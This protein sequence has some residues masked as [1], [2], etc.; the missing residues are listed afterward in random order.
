MVINPYGK[1]MWI[2]SIRLTG[3]SSHATWITYKSLVSMWHYGLLD[4]CVPVTVPLSFPSGHFLVICWLK[5]AVLGFALLLQ[6]I[7]SSNSYTNNWRQTKPNASL[8]GTGIAIK[9]GHG[10]KWGWPFLNFPFLW[11]AQRLRISLKLDPQTLCWIWTWS[12]MQYSIICL[13]PLGQKEDLLAHPKLVCPWNSI[14][15]KV[16]ESVYSDCRFLHKEVGVVHIHN[17]AF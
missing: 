9:D 7:A 5:W 8:Q 6:H 16:R 11:D 12:F 1:G 14:A 2:V 17:S 4:L 15:I 10:A 3:L 13:S